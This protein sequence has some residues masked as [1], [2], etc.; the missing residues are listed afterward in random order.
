[1][2]MQSSNVARL[3][4]GVGIGM[5]LALAVCGIATQLDAQEASS[6]PAARGA[7]EAT[8]PDLILVGGTVLTMDSAATVAQ[9]VAVRDGRIVAVGR[10]AAIRALA[11]SGT[12]VVELEGRTLAPGFFAPHDHFPGAGNVAV[13]LVDLNSPPI[14]RIETMA[15]LIEALRE[16]A[17]QVPA[18]TWVVGRGYD[19]TLLREQRHPTRGDL[20][21]VS[22]EHPIWITHISGHLGVA[23]TKALEVA[24]ITRDTPQPNGG[25]IRKDPTTGEPTGIFE[26]SGSLI[27]RHIPARNRAQR[28][29]SIEWANRE[30]LSKGVTTT[31]IA[32][33]V[34]RRTLTDFIGARREGI[35]DL[36]IIA[37]S[38]RGVRKSAE[39]KALLDT[40]RT[41]E[42][43]LGGVKVV[44]DG[45]IQGYTGYLTEPYHTPFQGNASYRGYP[46]RS[47]Q[48]L[49]NLITQI[50][51]E[52]FQSAVHAN[53]DAAIDDVLNA[54]DAALAKCPRS[55]ARHR[56]EHSQMAR[57]DQLARMKEL[58]V[59]PSIFVGH[60]YYWGDRHRDIFLGPERGARISP[61]RTATDAGVRWTLHDDTPVT[62]VNPLQLVWAA[63]NRVT[64]SGQL[65]GGGERV[66][67]LEALR[68]VTSDA[69]WQNFVEDERGSIEVGKLADFV[70]L[71]DNPLTVAPEKIREIQVL[72]T[73]IGGRSVYVR[74][75]TSN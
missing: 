9:A 27:T 53:G 28:F 14:G 44:Q 2:Q 55:D 47:R 15:E 51:C 74:A 71:S 3:R 13:H 24:G 31:V 60:V 62:P 46:R 48:A 8:S 50:H 63:V 23:N 45:S 56:I 36:R 43:R 41:E 25:V 38:A 1:M 20:D 67:P 16:R 64:T 61:L 72:E 39:T 65:L 73:I 49:A 30:Y 34:S 58:G 22:T 19:D 32:S 10:D 52:G 69:A 40:V 5:F 17:L 33:N 59:T 70:I 54:Y 7:G 12:R 42:L 29:A 11:G 68:G 66:T 18:G 26:E 57:P 75:A 6:G 4:R 21:L 37:M 35:L